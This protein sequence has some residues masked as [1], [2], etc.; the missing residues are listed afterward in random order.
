MAARVRTAPRKQAV[1]P[2]AKATVDVILEA[3]AHLLVRE[4]YDRTSTNKV[5]VAA[6]VSIGSLYQY[7]PSKEALVA[8]LMDRH[9]DEMMALV[10]GKTAEVWAEP[11]PVVVETLVRAMIEAHAVDPK[12]HKVF[13]EQVPRVGRLERLHDLEREVLGLARAFLEA[14]KS[15]LRPLDLDVAA[16]VSVATIEALTHA[17]VL[18]R[19]DLLDERLVREIRDVVV[20]YLLP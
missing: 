13:V 10:R 5:A 15:E 7:F 4:G 16:F 19:E 1:Q 18:V 11:V 2:R 6:G 8:A 12:L 3:T 9:T 20:R 17:A 14:H